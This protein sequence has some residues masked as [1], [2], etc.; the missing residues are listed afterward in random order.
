MPRQTG[1]RFKTSLR[2][3]QDGVGFHCYNLALRA[4]LAEA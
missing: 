3:E 4:E 2:F 1:P